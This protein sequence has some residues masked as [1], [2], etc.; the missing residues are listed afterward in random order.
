VIEQRARGLLVRRALGVVPADKLHI[1]HDDPH[2]LMVAVAARVAEA[3]QAKR[4]HRELIAALERG[5]RLYQQEAPKLTKSQRRTMR[6]R[7][8]LV[9][10]VP[11]GR[12]PQLRHGTPGMLKRGCTCAECKQGR[13]QRQREYRARLR[14]S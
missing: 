14:A 2:E 13:T 1:E 9:G 6:K 8:G 5:L 10:K 11:V 3:E 4:R 12:P 7:L